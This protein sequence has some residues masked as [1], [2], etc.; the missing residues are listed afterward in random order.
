M[1]LLL[2]ECVSPRVADPL[3]EEGHFVTPLRNLGELGKPD[4]KVLRR[5]IDEDAVLVT[6]DARDFRILVAREEIHPGL[7]I[8]PNLDGQQTERL[9]RQAI[10][11]LDRCGDPMDVM[12][13]HVLEITAAGSLSIYDL[14]TEAGPP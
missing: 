12:V 6:Q 9:L 7:L 4:Y 5:C 13:N 1:R 11:Y 3:N 14:P 8:L 10:E 2:D